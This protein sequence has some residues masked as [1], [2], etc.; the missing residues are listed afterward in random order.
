MATL[1]AL[2]LVTLALLA[3]APAARAQTGSQLYAQWC[4]GCHGPASGNVNNVLAGKDWTYIKLAIDTRL[5]MNE[6]LR[7]FYDEGAITDEN[8]MSI[9]AYLQTFTGG[10]SMTVGPVVEY[11]NAGFGHYFMTADADE[12]TGLDAGAFDYAFIRSGLEFDAYAAPSAGKVAVC[13]FFTT[14]GTFGQKSSHFYTANAAECEGLKLNPAWVYEKIAFYI[15]VPVNGNCPGGTIPI[16]RM[17]NNGQTGAPNHRFTSNLFTYQD[18]TSS[19]GWAP[20]G[21]A[22]CAPP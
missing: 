2:V 15:A 12:I 17:Y 20:E 13:R 8:L 5:M 18:H 3:C 16:Y 9:A 14:P 4:V 7:P 1:R 21:I 22:F 6:A 10:V 19:K 11:Y